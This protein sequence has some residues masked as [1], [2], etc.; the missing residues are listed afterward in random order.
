MSFTVTFDQAAHKR[1]SSQFLRGLPG[2][3]GRS[4]KRTAEQ[5]QSL[6]VAGLMGI[7][8]DRRVDTGALVAAYRS[9]SVSTAPNGTVEATVDAPHAWPVEVGTPTTEPGNHLSRALRVA[10]RSIGTAKGRGGIGS[11]IE[12]LWQGGR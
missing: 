9:A 4:S 3:V 12:R 5:V 7:G 2:A 10:L 1:A 8:G 11:E 6:V